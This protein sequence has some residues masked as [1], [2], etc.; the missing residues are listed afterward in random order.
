[1]FKLL[2]QGYREQGERKNHARSLSSY[3]AKDRI[4]HVVEMWECEISRELRRDE[5]MKEYFDNYEL[6]DPLE[7]RHAF[8]VGEPTPR[9][10]FTNVRTTRRLGMFG[11]KGDRVP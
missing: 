10:C 5:E 6:T 9:N 1:M 2:C 3:C 8:M 7:P 4:P 11:E